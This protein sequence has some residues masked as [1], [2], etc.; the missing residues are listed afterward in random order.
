MTFLEIVNEVLIRLRENTVADVNT[1]NYSKLIGVFVNDA[2]RSVEDAWT[3]DVLYTT[4][5]VVT[6]AGTTDYVVTGSGLR[7]KDATVNNVTS[8]HQFPLQA[9]PY[10]WI[11]NQL[12]LTTTTPNQP[13]YYSWNGN[14]GTDSKIAVYPT[15]NGTYTLNVNLCVPQLPLVNNTDTLLVQSEPVILG[16]YARALVERGEDGG[17]ASSEAYGLFRSVLS[18]QISIEM[19]RDDSM[20]TWSVV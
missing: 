7:H 19:S 16:A 12:Q 4:I 18:D 6:A 5:P 15:P 14:N 13:G 9:V 1:N 10:T 11:Q 17:L 20:T 3:W 2:K 8:G